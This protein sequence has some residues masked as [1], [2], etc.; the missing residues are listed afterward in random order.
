M[1]RRL[2]RNSIHSSRNSQLKPKDE[3]AIS[4]KFIIWMKQFCPGTTPTEPQKWR[5]NYRVE[6]LSNEILTILTNL[7][8]D[9]G[10]R[11]LKSPEFCHF[12]RSNHM[13]WITYSSINSKW[14]RD[15]SVCQKVKLSKYFLIG[16]FKQLAPNQTIHKRSIR[17]KLTFEWLCINFSI[18]STL[19]KNHSFFDAHRRNQ[20]HIRFIFSNDWNQS[21]K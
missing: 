6:R 5:L 4:T 21:W 10:R 7:S 16:I 2:G 14:K 18:S 20:V 3:Q 12:T 9:I 11:W 1:Y 8:D 19:R 15:W 13:I 17:K